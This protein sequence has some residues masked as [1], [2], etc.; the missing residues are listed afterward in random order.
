MSLCLPFLTPTRLAAEDPPATELLLS[1]IHDKKIALIDLSHALEDGIPYFPGGIPFRLEPV[2]TFSENGYAT[3][4]F[5]MGEHTGTHMDAPYHFHEKGQTVDE[6]ELT[7][8]ISQACVFDIRKKAKENPDYELSVADLKDWENTHGR[9]PDKAFIVL[10]TGQDRHWDNTARYVN[11]GDDGMPHFPGLSAE[12]A[13]FLASDRDIVGAGT[14]ALSVDPG[15]NRKLVVHRLLH[16][17]GKYH[18]ENLTRL[19]KLPPKGSLI[20]AFP[21]PVK[22]GSGAPA[23]V[24]AFV[25]RD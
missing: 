2:R 9:I 11:K 24:I 16:Q 1:E 20:G 21:I 6:I 7:R 15:K 3:H 19:E 13:Q 18:L 8:M 22:R 4:R 12:L 17:A 14:D 25:A 23:R 5:S 10:F